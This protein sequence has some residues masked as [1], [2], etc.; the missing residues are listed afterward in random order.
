MKTSGLIPI[1]YKSDEQ[2][3]VKCTES[4]KPDIFSESTSK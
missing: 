2:V 4:C 3:G 1:Q